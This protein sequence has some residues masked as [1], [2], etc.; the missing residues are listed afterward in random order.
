MFGLTL[1]E[2]DRNKATLLHHASRACQLP[3]MQFLIENGVELDAVD[4]S[5]NTALHLAAMACDIDGISLLLQSGA[6]SDLL[7]HERNALLHLA[8][9]DMSGHNLKA[10]LS[11]PINVHIRGQHNRSVLHILCETDNVEGCKVMNEFI[12]IQ[13]LNDCQEPLK[14]CD[15]DDFTP[16]YLA[17]RKNA[18]RILEREIACWKEMGQSVWLLFDLMNEKINTPLHVA[19]DGCNYEVVCILLEHGTNPTV[20]KGYLSPPLYL[21]CSLGHLGI[22]KAMVQYAGIEILQKLDCFHHVPLHY[23]AISIHSTSIISYILEESQEI[24]IDQQDSKGKTPL[25]MSI[26]SGNLAG[27]KEL[28]ARGSDPLL[29]DE[30]GSTALH[31]AVLHNRFAII[32]ELMKVPNSI[33]LLTDVNFKG[34]STV[35]IA[36]KLRLGDVV[37]D[38]IYPVL[39]QF[40]SHPMYVKDPYGNNYIHLAA[41]SGN[42]KLLLEFLHVSNVQELLNDTNHNGMT[43]LHCAAER[44]KSICIE[45]LINNGAIGHKGYGGVTP[46]MTA[47]SEGHVNCAKLLYNKACVFQLNLQDDVGN[48][49]LHHSTRSCNSSMIQYL[50]DLNSKILQNDCGECFLDLITYCSNEDCGLVVNHKRWQECLDV[51]SPVRDAPMLS[52]VKRIPAVAKVL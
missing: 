14:T 23:R 41:A 40:P 50:L 49:A 34:Y 42:W 6:S 43:P 7:N 52:L 37:L 28:L 32:T 45:H 19:V 15:D 47:C 36:P 38:L 44:G 31:L 10:C 5:G 48:T 9:K 33:Q 26:S 3:V 11:H 17:A 24:V 30:G 1:R 21:A 27:V 39:L 13:Q 4:E 12:K 18:Y 46:F 25:H 22:V 16:I 8:A 29:R 20:L 51:I 2:R 35:H